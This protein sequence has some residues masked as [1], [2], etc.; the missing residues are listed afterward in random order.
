VHPSNIPDR[1]DAETGKGVSR[2]VTIPGLAF[3]LKK[4][5]PL[6]FAT[7]GVIAGLLGW[8][9]LSPIVQQLLPRRSQALAPGEIV[10][11]SISPL[12]AKVPAPVITRTHPSPPQEPS[13][14]P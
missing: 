1:P 8:L 6:A 7:G 3:A 2:T 9:A 5:R 13:P 4:P 11:E 10:I 12:P 14:G